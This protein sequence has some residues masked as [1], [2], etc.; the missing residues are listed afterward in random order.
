MAYLYMQNIKEEMVIHL[1]KLSTEKSK[2][3]LKKIKKMC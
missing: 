1:H 2:M 3:Q